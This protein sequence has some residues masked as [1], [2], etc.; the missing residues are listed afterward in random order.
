MLAGK[1][2]EIPTYES[3]EELVDSMIEQGVLKLDE[4]VAAILN[5]D[6]H[7]LSDRAK[8]RHF[9][10]VTGLTRKSLEQIRR[11]QEAVRQLKEGKRPIDVAV[12][13]GFADQ[14]HLSKS[15]KKI[16]HRNPSEI[17]EIHKL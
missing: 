8:Q 11:A 6:S 15:L 14:A 17:D 4:V 7:A 5:G 2:F 1:I 9:S 3:A 10:E 13:G 12:D 16:M